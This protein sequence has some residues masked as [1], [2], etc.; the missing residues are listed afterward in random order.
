LISD[1]TF[2]DYTLGWSYTP[3]NHA[4][5]PTSYWFQEATDPDFTTLTINEFRTSTQYSFSNKSSGTYYYRV[6]AINAY[7]EGAWSN[8][9]SVEVKLSGY[10]DDFSDAGS[11]WPRHVFKVDDRDVLS[12]LYEGETYRLKILLDPYGQNNKRMGV[13]P[14][15]Y[16][17]QDSSYDVEVKHWFI[18]ADDQEMDPYAGKAGLVFGG[19]PSDKG[20][21]S[22]LYVVE[23]NF[24]GECAVSRYSDIDSYLPIVWL[25]ERRI[26]MEWGSCPIGAGY[27]ARVHA[28][29][30]VRGDYATVYLNGTKI[31]TFEG[32]GGAGY[33]GL[34]TGSWERTPVESKFDEFRVREK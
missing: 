5:P 15:P 1:D 29:V 16:V 2:G 28:L 22:T 14:A 11:G 25:P 7:G 34:M 31:G 9:V 17:H 4:Y 6:A 30:H 21:F 18:K 20:Y 3:A 13:V 19:V 33:V 10:Y 24:E 26:Y 27:D 23:W 12:T 32:I 8:V